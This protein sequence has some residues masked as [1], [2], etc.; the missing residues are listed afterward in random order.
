MTTHSSVPWSYRIWRWGQRV[1][2]YD[3]Q[4]RLARVTQEYVGWL[5]GEYLDAVIAKA[6]AGDVFLQNLLV[7][8]DEMIDMGILDHEGRVVLLFDE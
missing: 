7:A 2:V 6:T 8:R 1:D 5:G 3:G 4:G